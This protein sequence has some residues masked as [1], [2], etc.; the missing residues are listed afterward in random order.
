MAWAREVL[1][2]RPLCW[3]DHSLQICAPMRSTACVKA[4]Y[5]L[6]PGTGVEAAGTD[7]EHAP[8]L[9]AGAY[10]MVLG[11]QPCNSLAVQIID[12]TPTAGLP[13][14]FGGHIAA[15]RV[16]HEETEDLPAI[17]GTLS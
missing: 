13:S 11:V 3:S 12:P 5:R 17:G 6:L 8:D 10:M 4:A 9:R 1:G 15:A 2:D 7:G 16:Q 14:H